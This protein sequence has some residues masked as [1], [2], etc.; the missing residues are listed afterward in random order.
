MDSFLLDT[1]FSRCHSKPNVY[2]KKVGSHLIILV[3]SVDDHILTS[4][5]PKLLTRVKSN[6]KKKFEMT[7]SGYMHYFLGLQVL[8]TPHQIHWKLISYYSFF[9]EVEDQAVVNE[10]K[11]SYGFN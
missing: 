1:D 2:S 4:S 5:D 7:E 11:K 9:D 10:V 8:Q 6:L 3:L